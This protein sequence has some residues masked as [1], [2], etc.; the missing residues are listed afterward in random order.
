MSTGIGVVVDQSGLSAQGIVERALLAVDSGAEALW[1]TQQPNQRDATMLASVIASHTEK[2]GIGT[3]ILQTYTRP[4]VVMA[5]TALTLDE[6]CGGRF[7][8]GLGAGHKMTGEWMM[9]SQYPPP[10]PGMREYLTVVT[11]LIRTGEVNVSGRW[12]SG[13]ASYSGPRRP[14]LPVYVG[15]LGPQVLEIAGELADGVILWFATPED[16][17]ERVMPRLRAGWTRRGGDRGDF[18]VTVMIVAGVSDNPSEEREALRRLIGGY[19]R[20]ENYRKQFI[21]SGFEA[22]VQAGRMSDDAVRQ[23]GAVGS[24]QEVR[25]QMAAFREAGATHF[26]VSPLVITPEFEPARYTRTLEAMHGG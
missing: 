19:L 13:H 3:A 22:D 25:E 20:M 16:V 4:P 17:R 7:M 10:G 26:A 21:S 2:V 5:Q 9:G 1:M 11:D 15:T 18:S 24:A 12:H 8:L 14:E 6:A 23:M